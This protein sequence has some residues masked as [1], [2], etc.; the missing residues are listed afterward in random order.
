MIR[1]NDDVSQCK[2]HL[3]K[4]FKC[5]K[6]QWMIRAPVDEPVPESEAGAN[7]KKSRIQGKIWT[8]EWSKTH[9]F[10]SKFLAIKNFLAPVV[11]VRFCKMYLQWLLTKG[12][13]VCV[14]EK[15]MKLGFKKLYSKS[16]SIL[17][18]F[19]PTSTKRKPCCR[20]VR[21][22][23]SPKRSPS[24]AMSHR[25]TALCQGDA[26][27]AEQLNTHVTLSQTHMPSWKTCHQMPSRLSHRSSH[28]TVGL[29]PNRFPGGD[30]S[31][32]PSNACCWEMLCSEKDWAFSNKA[33]LYLF[34][35]MLV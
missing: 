11:A 3:S 7:R 26:Q 28:G 9:E 30:P 32:I 34:R 35:P 33:R 8:N 4:E 27:V 12:G 29:V 21:R 20:R 5:G 25:S 1:Y 18:M 17:L 22:S 14:L 31:T 10:Q 16:C 13:C 6:T 15:V 24:R 2:G 19:P 23:Q